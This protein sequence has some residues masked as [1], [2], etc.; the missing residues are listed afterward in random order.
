[1]RVNNIEITQETIEATRQYY[2]N[3]YR[4]CIE[5]ATSGRV[6]VNDLA[7]YVES[8]ERHIARMMAGESDHTLTFVQHALYIQ[9]GECIGIL[10]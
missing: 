3:L 7:K 8:E 9:T 1:M 10:G 2:I 4:A 5:D 6:R